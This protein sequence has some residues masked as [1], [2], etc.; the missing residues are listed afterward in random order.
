MPRL[1][2]KNLTLVI[3][4]LSNFRYCF[5]LKLFIL[6]YFCQNDACKSNLLDTCPKMN[7]VFLQER[8]LYRG[9]M[10]AKRVLYISPPLYCLKC[11]SLLNTSIRYSTLLILLLCNLYLRYQYIM[12]YFPS[13]SPQLLTSWGP[14][15]VLSELVN[16][17]ILYGYNMFLDIKA[18][19]I[20][21]LLYSS[22]S[23]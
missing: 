16:L 4:S 9:Q 8:T 14:C 3:F 6:T 7:E 22:K 2:K 10:W 18:F 21:H 12:V 19:S 23:P 15:V 5:C 13:K 20:V 1:R 11:E 17:Y